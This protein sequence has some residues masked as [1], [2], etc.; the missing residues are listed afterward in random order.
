MARA[1]NVD[2]STTVNRPQKN[3]GYTDA[4]RSN[5]TLIQ[6]DQGSIGDLP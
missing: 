6:F 3:R 5:E 1:V 4:A 2:D